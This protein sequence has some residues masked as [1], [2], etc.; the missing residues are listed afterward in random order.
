MIERVP[1]GSG[2]GGQRIELFDWGE[3][4]CPFLPYQLAFL[5]HVHELDVGQRALGRFKRLEPQHG[6]GDPLHAAMVLLHQII[7]IV[8]LTDDDRGPVLRVVASD[9]RGIGLAPINRD[10][11]WHAMTPNRLGEKARGGALVALVREQEING[12]AGLI[13]RTIQIAPF[14]T[15]A[16]VGFIHP[17]TH[18]HRPLTAMERGL[19]LG[20]VFQH[21]AIDGGVIHRDAALLHELFELVVAQGIRHV[22]ADTGQDDVLLKM[23]SLEVHHALPPLL[24]LDDRGRSY[25]K[26]PT[27]KNLRHIPLW[28]LTFRENPYL[29]PAVRIQDDRGQTV[30][31]TSPY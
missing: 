16:D 9:G 22:P 24:V 30:V 29:S 20:T 17:P 5:Q 21:P 13:H 10:R 1:L 26:K 7:E 3:A 23:G 14:P 8:H 4:F 12:L 27:S 18:P 2:L 15:Y 6:T 11:L 25:S 28:S 31:S 19:E